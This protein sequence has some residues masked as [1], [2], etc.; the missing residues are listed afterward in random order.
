MG[1]PA[2]AMLIGA[3]GAPLLAGRI[4][5]GVIMAGTLALS[6]AGYGLLA[7]AGTDSRP[8]VVAGF[9]LV[10]LGLGVIAALGTDIVMGATPPDRSGS[11]AALSE[12]V[13]EFGIAA[14][15]ALL[16]S[17]TTALYRREIETPA[18]LP[19]SVAETYGDSL[20]GASSVADRIP[21]DAV[22]HARS[23]F[24]GGLNTAALAAGIAIAAASSACF[25]M[26]RHIRTPDEPDRAAEPIA[27]TP[28]SNR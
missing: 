8:A 1:P 5:P 21:A 27:S 14:G 3:I 16:G 2:L 10:Y 19:A 23:V 17:L 4:P 15:V 28:G 11:A 20:A 12:T 7:S 25:V 18:E 6:L 24:T 22:D 26:L 9:A 13:Q